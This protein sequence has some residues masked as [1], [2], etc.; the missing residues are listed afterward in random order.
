RPAVLD[1]LTQRR[2]GTPRLQVDAPRLPILEQALG[3]AMQALD[4]LP[5]R[6]EELDGLAVVD[7]L[8]EEIERHRHPEDGILHLV[9]DAGHELAERRELLAAADRLLQREE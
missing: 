7:L 8:L 2:R 6:I 4:P 1:R 3:E 5:E 9:S